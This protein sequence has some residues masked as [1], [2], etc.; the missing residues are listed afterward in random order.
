MR[1]AGLMCG[2]DMDFRHDCLKTLQ[3]V[4]GHLLDIPNLDEARRGPVWKMR[5][6]RRLAV[7]EIGEYEIETFARRIGLQGHLAGEPCFLGRL[8]DALAA[9]VKFPAVIDAADRLTLDPAEMQRCAAMR[10][11]IGDDLRHA[12]LRAVDR[13]VLAHDAQRLGAAHRQVAAAADRMPE[14]THENAARRRVSERGRR[15]DRDF[16]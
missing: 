6:W 16:R 10:A 3:V 15:H 12:R 1:A 4:A 9:M 8:L 13:E 14:L 11:A 7:A 5:E 2:S